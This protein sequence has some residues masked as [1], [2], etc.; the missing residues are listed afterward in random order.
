[1]FK[2]DTAMKQK[3]KQNYSIFNTIAYALSNLWKWDKEMF[4]YCIVQIPVN[5]LLPL[6]AILLSTKSVE[7]LTDHS[8]FIKL[9]EMIVLLSVATLVLNITNNIVKSKI[10]N[11]GSR[12]RAKYGMLVSKKIIETDYEN[13]NNTD[14]QE[15]LQKA[16]DAIS[17]ITSGTERILRS[18][19]SIIS[20]MINL[21]TYGAFVAQINL[22]LLIALSV[23]IV[24]EYLLNKKF[25]KWVF[26]NKD[27]WI[28]IDR[29][30]NY[31]TNKCGQLDWGKD[32]RFYKMRD[33]MNNLFNMFLKDRLYW[34]SKVN[35]RSFI[36]STL[37]IILTFLRDG[38]SYGFL[39]F[40]VIYKGLTP[41]AFVFN[42]NGIEQFSTNFLTLFNSISEMYVIHRQFC[43]LR[44]FLNMKDNT[45]RG[46][47]IPLPEETCQIEFKN[48]TFYYHGEKEPTLKDINFQI[49]KGEKVAI[50]GEN[51]A[52]KTT[53]VKLLCGLY[54]PTSGEILIN[55]QS[56]PNYNLIDYFQ[57][58]STVF[59]DIYFLPTSILKNIALVPEG[60]INMDKVT[61]IVAKSGLDGIIRRLPN[62]INTNL[63][64]SVNDEAIDLS[65]GE[66]QRL[67]LA[68]ALYKEGKIIVLDEPTA[69]LDPIM[70]NKLY[71]EYDKITNG[72]TSIYISHRLSSTS[73]CDRILFINKGTIAEMGSHKELME[74][75][76]EYAR[77]FKIQSHY[78]NN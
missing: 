57:L 31:I 72:N 37:V 11:C 77:M 28:P 56:I 6:T 26:D 30:I 42:F 2:K 17:D 50:V 59:Q 27:S 68:R 13:L 73:F 3:I 69:A 12:V 51:G 32:I 25:N 23:P 54:K 5:V 34:L 20:S 62:G 21:V 39:I 53:L 15:K 48:V 60:D 8:R 64:K 74:I 44:D 63:I 33:W 78:Y 45:N 65:G 66:K 40:S 67:A 9:A 24:I 7:L 18:F 75:G 55:N 35:G 10:I 36:K 70:E 38:L 58:Y 1:M 49:K 47:G 29:K 71:L 14:G 76:G 61:D 43:D 41:S 16:N 4:F 46:K 22:F 19:I 52:G